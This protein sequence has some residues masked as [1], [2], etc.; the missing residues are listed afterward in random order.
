MRHKKLSTPELIIKKSKEVWKIEKDLDLSYLRKKEKG[1]FGAITKP[2]SPLLQIPELKDS[3][4]T[5]RYL[6]VV[7]KL[8]LKVRKIQIKLPG[9][10]YL[11]WEV[12]QI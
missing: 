4:P 8:G 11:K 12:Y 7:K 1:L 9:N 5:Q 10:R 2:S 6:W 3:S